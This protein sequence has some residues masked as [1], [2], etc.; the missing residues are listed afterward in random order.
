MCQPPQFRRRSACHQIWRPR[1][2]GRMQ[3]GICRARLNELRAP[4]T[5]RRD[6]QA[7]QSERLR[8]PSSR[9]SPVAV[10]TRANLERPLPDRPLA[11]RP[12]GSCGRN[13]QQK[14][15]HN[16]RQLRSCQFSHQRPPATGNRREYLEALLNTYKKVKKS[17]ELLPRIDRRRDGVGRP[18]YFKKLAPVGVDR[19]VELRQEPR[20]VRLGE[21]GGPRRT[22][23]DCRS[24]SSSA[25]VATAS[26][27]ASSVNS[28]PLGP[29]T[30]GPRAGSGRRAGCR[31]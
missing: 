6:C 16:R 13:P 5:P 3:T 1:P 9:E 17:K 27:I 14:T 10:D 25:R 26:P 29:R 31:L 21:G 4:Q 22:R 15:H 12:G 24:M 28:S 30:L 7:C 20:A 8:H 2:S 19:L 18:A 23:P 11:A